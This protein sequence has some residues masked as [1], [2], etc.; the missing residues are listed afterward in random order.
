MW[1]NWWGLNMTEVELSSRHYTLE[2]QPVWCTLCQRHRNNDHSFLLVVICISCQIDG[3]FCFAFDFFFACSSII[4]C[5]TSNSGFLFSF[6]LIFFLNFIFRDIFCKKYVFFF[7]LKLTLLQTFV[8]NYMLLYYDWT[9]SCLKFGFELPISIYN[10]LL[11]P[12]HDFIPI[13]MGISSCWK[14]ILFESFIYWKVTCPNCY[15]THFF[16]NS[17]S[18]VI[19]TIYLMAN[20]N[21]KIPFS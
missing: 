1:Y 19:K 2:I 17:F 5:S 12:T 15:L 11:N 18:Y 8:R 9:L 10:H 20:R 3:I 13:S 6:C 7:K 14:W 4:F 16:S 21:I